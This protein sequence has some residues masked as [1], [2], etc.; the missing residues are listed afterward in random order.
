[1]EK[2]SKQNRRDNPARYIKLKQ[3]KRKQNKKRMSWKYVKILVEG[4]GQGT[5]RKKMNS[6]TEI[7]LF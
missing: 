7:I 1:M 6:H 2:N 3:R 4:S 5:H